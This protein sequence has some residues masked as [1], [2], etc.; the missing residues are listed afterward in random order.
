MSTS[1]SHH[2]LKSPVT[3]AI[4]AMGGDHGTNATIS[5]A[6]LCLKQRPDTLFLLF[7]ERTKIEQV[8]AHFPQL[9]Q[10]SQIIHTDK[11]I[12][13]EE[14][15]SVALRQGKNS[16]MRLAINAVSEGRAD[17]VISSGNTGALMAMSKMVLKTLP[18]IRRPAIASVFPTK[19][20]ETI[21]LD[22]GANSVCDSDNLVQFAILGSVFAKVIKN[23]NAP[24]VGLL[25][26]GS[27]DMKGPDHI[28]VAAEMLRQ[29]EF[30]GTFH[31]YIEGND[32]PRGTTDVVVTDGFTGNVALKVAEGT[33]ELISHF[34]RDAFKS[35]F[36]SMI[37]A[38]FAGAAMKKLKKRLDPRFY[39]GGMFLGLNGICVKSHGSSD[40]YGF[41]RALIVAADLAA[42]NYNQRV[43]AELDALSEREIFETLGEQG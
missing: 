30:P 41:S 38:L 31:G 42:N 16:S 28:R 27:E 37:G 33:S 11:M 1:H 18:E 20:G 26:V 39:N 22:L 36:L 23:Q 40:D 24:T 8:M 43:A 5:G 4:D 2:T 25:N 32:I 10:A 12:S 9:K 14:K 6:A 7:G 34:I 13:N 19:K 29:I 35:S 15:P 3:L 21:M 17:A